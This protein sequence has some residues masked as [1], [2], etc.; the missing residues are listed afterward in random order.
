MKYVLLLLA[1]LSGAAIAGPG[2]SSGSRAAPAAA[3]APARSETR[4]PGG[5]EHIPAGIGTNV[6]PQVAN[7][8]H[9]A[10]RQDALQHAQ[11]V[12]ASREQMR[13]DALAR[14]ASAP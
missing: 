5:S 6:A 8:T 11:G 13:A 12:I 4:L 7:R 10:R 3:N 9:H 1:A 14:A 2:E